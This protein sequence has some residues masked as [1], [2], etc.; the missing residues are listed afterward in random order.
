MVERKRRCRCG[1]MEVVKPGNKFIHGHNATAGFTGNRHAAK[2][3]QRISEINKTK[4]S[5]GDNPFYG[6]TH[7]V[8][9]RAILSK[10]GKARVGESN[11]FYGKTH[12]CESKVKTSLALSGDKHWNWQGGIK[13]GAY[14]GAWAD[15]EYKESIKE[16]DGYKCM[17]T[18]CW[19]AC[20]RLSI[21]HIDYDKQNCSP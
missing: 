8:E 3:K 5:G 19:G 6:K 17:N 9:V 1:C 4:L 18:D 2:T 21:H 20:T 14:C 10:A 11:P 16:R 15:P 13:N 12:S 7:S